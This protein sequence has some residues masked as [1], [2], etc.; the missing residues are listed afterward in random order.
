[1]LHST[2]TYKKIDLKIQ[3]QNKLSSED[4]MRSNP[5]QLFSCYGLDLTPFKMAWKERMLFF[6]P[7]VILKNLEQPA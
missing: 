3:F 7:N 5:Q 6:T 1:M 2:N 4:E